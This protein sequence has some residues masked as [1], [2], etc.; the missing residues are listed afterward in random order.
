M[1]NIK[2]KDWYLKVTKKRKIKNIIMQTLILSCGV[3][4]ITP[5]AF[6]FYHI[7]KLGFPELNFTFFTELPTPTGQTG[8]GM[9]NSI[10]GSLTMIGLASLV[11]VPIGVLSGVYL[12]EYGQSHSWLASFFR[13]IVDLLASLP[14]IV[15]GLFIYSV[16]V[17]PM[18]T[19]SAYAGSAALSILM[20][21]IVI[22]TTEEVLK[23]LPIHVREAGLALGIPRW[24]VII[25]IVLNGRKGAVITGVMLAVSRIAGET[26]PLLVTAFGNRYWLQNL[27]QPIASIPV[28]IY[29]YAISPFEDWHKQAWAGALTLVTL[30]F[31]LNLLSRTLLSR[32]LNER[33]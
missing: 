28:Q 2:E 11:S 23:L 7:V 32:Q 31:I 27:K 16:M 14:S 4:A 3:V 21:P 17:I 18:K 9:G 20:I 33:N 13:L 22:K 26:A 25:S 29:N 5:L 12:S 24:R 1:K 19:F 15:V 8:G 6:V 10:I 30:I